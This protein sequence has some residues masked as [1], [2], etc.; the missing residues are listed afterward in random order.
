VADHP[1]DGWHPGDD[2]MWTAPGPVTEAEAQQAAA[3]ISRG[4]RPGAGWTWRPAP[5]RLRVLPGP[6]P[7]AS[8]GADVAGDLRAAAEDPYGIWM[9]TEPVPARDGRLARW[10]RRVRRGGQR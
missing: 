5:G 3:A 7:W 4:E 2:G 6:A 10:L 8:P 9:T 1:D